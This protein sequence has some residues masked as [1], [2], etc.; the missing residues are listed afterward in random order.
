MKLQFAQMPCLSAYVLQLS[1]ELIQRESRDELL[2]HLVFHK[3]RTW[4]E[5]TAN[6]N[7]ILETSF[8]QF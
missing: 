8:W 5:Y 7:K 1:Q 2:Q 4:V 3:R 6:R